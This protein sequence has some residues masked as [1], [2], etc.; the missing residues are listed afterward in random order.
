ML[1][2]E[3]SFGNNLLLGQSSLWNIYRRSN[4]VA[5][6]VVAGVIAILGAIVTPYVAFVLGAIIPGEFMVGAIIAGG[7]V[8]RAFI[9]EKLSPEH[10]SP[11]SNS[12][13]SKFRR[14]ICR[15]AF[16]EEQLSPSAEQMWS[17]Q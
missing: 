3:L 11:E 1:P 16:D 14:S 17:E 12:P 6:A 4:I 15:K 9:V 7:I 13:W 10:L 8:A 5:G 2:R